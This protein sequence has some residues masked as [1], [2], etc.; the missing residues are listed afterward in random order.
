MATFLVVVMQRLSAVLSAIKPTQYAHG[1]CS[2]A[3]R[4]R[5]LF[6][7]QFVEQEGNSY[8][9]WLLQG[10]CRADFSLGWVHR[11]EDMTGTAGSVCGC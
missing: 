6:S 2:V 8:R 3:K 9:P 7:V 10:L 11:G 5:L 4:W 1:G